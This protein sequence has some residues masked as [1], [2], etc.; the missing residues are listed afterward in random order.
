MAKMGDF[1]I[2]G[3]LQ[4]QSQ[5]NR[6]F[7]DL[8]DFCKEMTKELAARLLGKVIKRTPVD[9]GHLRRGWTAGQD[10]AVKDYLNAISVQKKGS[11]YMITIENPVYYGL[12]VE[13]GHR[14]RD[15][16][17]WIEGRFMLTISELELKTQA[18]SIIKRKLDKKLRELFK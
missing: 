17:R 7:I 10:R 9:T 3:F 8:D 16:K 4:L 13:F 14:T 5:L 6:V 2:D 12:Y 1:N 18:P 15:G 11:T